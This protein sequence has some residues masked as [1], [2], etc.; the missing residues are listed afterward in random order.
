MKPVVENYVF[1]IGI[2]FLYFNL[3]FRFLSF[4]KRVYI[5]R[6][7]LLLGV[8][9]HYNFKKST[10]KLDFICID[11]HAMNKKCYHYFTTLGKLACSKTFKYEFI[12][13]SQTHINSFL[14]LC[15]DENRPTN[16]ICSIYNLELSIKTVKGESCRVRRSILSNF[17]FLYFFSKN[18]FVVFESQIM[19]NLMKQ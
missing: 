15:R 10:N 6:E 9:L 8:L 17:T 19:K 18:L 11:V 13:D 1:S 3:P 7:F 5:D 4:F 2:V 14:L 12:F 16:F